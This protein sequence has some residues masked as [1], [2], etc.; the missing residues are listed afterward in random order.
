MKQELRLYNVIFPIWMLW[1]AP[2]AWLIA[3]PGN[4]I[5]DVVVLAVTLKVLGHGSKLAV[6]K[7]LWWKFWLFGF[8][9]DF[10]GV[11]ALLPCPFLMILLEPAAPWLYDALSPV[12]HNPF[13]SLPALAWVGA[14]VA[15]A[16]YCI[17]RFDRRAMKDCVL[18][19]ETE[20][21]RIA[22]TMAVVTAPWLFFLPV[23]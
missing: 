17:Y 15:L 18:L 20:K 1:L 16:G 2:Q 12:M 6:V 5:V 8:L 7:E 3:L 21:H 9:A 14:A 13:L 19:S 10:V 23:Y 4:L 22:L 11:A